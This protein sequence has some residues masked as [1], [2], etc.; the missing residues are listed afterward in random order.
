M[1]GDCGHITGD[2]RRLRTVLKKP[3]REDWTEE[4]VRSCCSADRP[5]QYSDAA[6]E[7]P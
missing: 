5:A 2:D 1:T 4:Q 6:V 3:A 7:I